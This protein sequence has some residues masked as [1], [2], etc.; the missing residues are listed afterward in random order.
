MQLNLTKNK[1]NSVYGIENLCTEFDAQM[2][3]TVFK[4]TL[5]Q[6]FQSALATENCSL[7]DGKDVYMN[8]AATRVQCTPRQP[9]YRNFTRFFQSNT[10]S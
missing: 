6:P 1:N 3:G 8:D 4:N 10:C 7:W 5:I 2:F 9:N